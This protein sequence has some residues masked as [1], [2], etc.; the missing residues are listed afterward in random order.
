MSFVWPN[1]PE[2]PRSRAPM[3]SILWHYTGPDGLLG[4]LSSNR[5]WASD[6]IAMNDRREL[7]YGLDVI[8]EE[9]EGMRSSVASEL[10]LCRIVQ[11]PRIQRGK[12]GPAPRSEGRPARSISLFARP[13]NP[14]H[15]GRVLRP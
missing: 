4:I 13:P 9:W 15:R 14:L 1:S 2:P 11:A 6:P 10:E 8:V 5:F 7:K 12:R 3:S